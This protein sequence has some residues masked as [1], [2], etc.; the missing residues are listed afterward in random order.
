MTYLQPENSNI[1][2]KCSKCGTMFSLTEH[3][4]SDCPVCGFHCDQDK[5]KIVDVSDEGY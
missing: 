5:C 3:K 2:Y 4:D 1:S